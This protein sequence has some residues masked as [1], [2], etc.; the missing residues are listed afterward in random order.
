MT[1]RSVLEIIVYLAIVIALTPILG[2]YM[3][4]VFAGERTW[5]DPVL[6]PVERGIYKV[7]GV[8]A[9]RDQGW[10]EWTVTM[11]IVNAASLVVLY[12]MQRLQQFLPLNP[13]G[14]GAVSPDSSWNTAVSFTTNTNWQGYSG[15][16]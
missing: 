4:R 5:L 6:R 16:S 12:A 8:D 11:L 3:K 9:S 2:A 10:V 7:C 15:E 13:N 1:A 14:F